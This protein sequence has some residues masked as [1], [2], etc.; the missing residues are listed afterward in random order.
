M[1]LD[2]PEIHAISDVREPISL[3]Q[4]A[5]QPTHIRWLQLTEFEAP[6]GL[7]TR[8]VAELLMSCLEQT[9]KEEDVYFLERHKP[10][11]NLGCGVLVEGN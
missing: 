9:C 3:H 2:A 7:K 1:S 8:A 5:Q 4:A 6:Q 10:F 11:D